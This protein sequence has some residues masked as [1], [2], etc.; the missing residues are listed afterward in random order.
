MTDSLSLLP[1]VG[2]AEHLQW[3]QEW[4]EKSAS[5]TKYKIGG[6]IFVDPSERVLSTCPLLTL[7]IG[8][9]GS[10]KTRLATEVAS[11]AAHMGYY[12]IW[13]SCREMEMATPNF[14]FGEFLG[15]L[16]YQL[17]EQLLAEIIEDIGPSASYLGL[18][19]PQLTERLQMQP[20]EHASCTRLHLGNALALLLDACRR[21]LG[22][23]FFVI[24][25]LHWMDQE[26]F[27]LLTY[28]LQSP[29]ANAPSVRKE[30]GYEGSEIRSP[31]LIL[32]T[33]HSELLQSNANLRVWIARQE[34]TK[35]LVR[36]R[37]SPL[38][39]VDIAALVRWKCWPT[40]N[41]TQIE[42]VA[43]QIY[44]LSQGN[45]FFASEILRQYTLP[46]QLPDL[47]VS[48]VASPQQK[49]SIEA[50]SSFPEL[51]A[52]A[53]EELL[54]RVS[55]TCNE[56][57]SIASA[58]G[59]QF[60]FAVVR[61]LWRTIK[62]QY[63]V[64][65]SGER[66][67]P[68]DEE[69]LKEALHAGLV[70]EMSLTNNSDPECHGEE[71]YCFW[72]PL[73]A[74][75]LQLRLSKPR[76]VQLS[77]LAAEI[78]HARTYAKSQLECLAPPVSIDTMKARRDRKNPLQADE[79]KDG[80]FALSSTKSS[81]RKDLFHVNVSEEIFIGQEEQK[82][83]KNAS[84]LDLP[85]VERATSPRP[86]DP[87]DKRQSKLIDLLTPKECEI[88]SLLAEGCTTEDIIQ[89]LCLSKATVRT[90]IR[91]L[92]GKLE[93]PSRLNAVLLWKEHMASSDSV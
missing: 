83:I 87:F 24:D 9:T 92:L 3:L 51:I 79:Y 77:L 14:L 20:P 93:V 41:E 32:A 15:M 60:D 90:H 89:K 13:I 88:L 26:T 76:L 63:N 66:N 71:R 8:E 36:L 11:V 67:M 16:L 2:Q 28:L 27:A 64:I 80:N 18:L 33:G 69:L 75:Y 43:Q 19:C 52:A 48:F 82:G 54:M 1:M 70:Y 78:N 21:K 74:R 72:H 22:P 61:Q 57:L 5:F 59:S 4:L 46:D 73:F 37:I 30:D 68:D 40:L 34:R 42:I 65:P 31:L 47:G 38:E 49:M 35:L 44:N 45:P 91:N 10:G 56:W 39:P 53:M 58:F 50:L 7:L 29:L 25:D 6:S 86:Q 81:S 23:L 85:S 12:P 84:V 55:G 62:K 17:P